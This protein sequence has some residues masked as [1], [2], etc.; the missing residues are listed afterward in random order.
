MLL[1]LTAPTGPPQNI[2]ALEIDESS[3]TLGWNPPLAS[4][5]NGL[6]TNY[7]I[8]VTTEGG[9]ILYFETNSNTYTVSN[10]EPYQ[11]YHFELAAET[12][13]GRGPFSISTPFLTGEAGIAVLIEEVTE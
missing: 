8:N 7:A 13:A 1:F 6:I 12:V 4:E 5:Q 10:L 9:N 2:R 3:I 11:V